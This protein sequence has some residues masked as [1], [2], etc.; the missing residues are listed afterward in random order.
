[1]E[2]KCLLHFEDD[3]SFR[4]VVNIVLSEKGYKLVQRASIGCNEIENI[5]NNQGGLENIMGVITDGQMPGG[6]PGPEIA[7]ELRKKGYNGPIVL[8]TGDPNMI[9]KFNRGAYSSI[10]DL[11]KKPVDYMELVN[12]AN[13]YFGGANE[14]WIYWNAYLWR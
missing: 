5:I 12:V 2:N 13:K 7:N 10:N 1:M 6:L 3:E 11:V 14:S 8:I 9:E 4:E